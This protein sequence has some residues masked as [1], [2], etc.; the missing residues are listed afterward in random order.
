MKQIEI[1]Q[2]NN[3]ELVDALRL[4]HECIY[5]EFDQYNITVKKD[6]EYELK[7]L[8]D[9]ANEPVQDDIRLIYGAF[10]DN[11]LVGFAGASFA[12]AKIQKNAMEIN[13]LFVNKEYRGRKIGLR[14]MYALVNEFSKL[15]R[16]NVILYNWHLW[17]S[18]N[19]YAHIGGELIKQVIQ[20]IGGTDQLVDI[21]YWKMD[22]LKQSLDGRLKKA[23]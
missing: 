1:K 20:K 4:H 22:D 23:V 19:F 3:E 10:S 2:L 18:N 12:E 6:F 21:F 11:I 7:Q 9:W 5:E 13:Y 14:L 17:K 8:V 16:K 15:K